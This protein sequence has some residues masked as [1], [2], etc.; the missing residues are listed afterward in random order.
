MHDKYKRL[1]KN[2]LLIFIGNI[3]S[4]LI[5]LLM[6]PFYTRWLTVE[7]Y[8]TTDI[9]NVYVA[10]LIGIVSCCIVDAI[11]IFPKDQSKER[12]SNYF[13]TGIAFMIISLLITFIIFYFLQHVFSYYNIL[14]TFNDNIWAIFAILFSTFGQQL[15]QQF[16]RSI[17]KIKIYSLTGLIQ[18]IF[19]TVFSFILI[20]KFNVYGFILASIFSNILAMIFAFI[21]SKSYSYFSLA[22]IRKDYFF[23]MLRFC[24]PLIPN[25]LMWWVVAALNRPILEVHL[26]L[27]AIGIFAVAN[28]FPSILATVYGIFTQSWQISVLEEFNKNGYQKFYNK[29]FRAAFVILILVL[30]MVTVSS[31]LLVKLFV[32]ESFFSAWI[33]VPILILAVFFTNI[34]GLVGSNFLATKQSKYY[35]YTSIV[36]CV[37][38]LLFNFILIPSWG[39]MGA[40][41][42][43]VLSHFSIAL[44]R[45]YLSWK[46]AKI[47]HIFDYII[48]LL[49]AL[50]VIATIL[51]SENLFMKVL[52]VSF[53]VMIIL[54]INKSVLLNLKTILKNK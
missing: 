54:I 50:G 22:A 18:T 3:G 23:E 28:K 15:V 44:M 45:I 24:L 2:T 14:K 20:P 19:L 53:A 47:E 26:G 48:M 35:L 8:G 9:I 41:I 10:F 6:L 51:L 36:G 39:I 25:G 38:S 13:S 11:F 27:Q 1:G 42:A 40:A 31:E 49:L 5:G 32:S 4:K 30:I 17:N 33:Y 37:V 29:I 21:F 46:Y 34:S 52:S 16:T 12:Q 7:E 43:V